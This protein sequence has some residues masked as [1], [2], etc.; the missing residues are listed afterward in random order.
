MRW[1]LQPL[2][3]SSGTLTSVAFH[4]RVEHIRGNA[5]DQLLS[6][7]LPNLTSIDLGCLVS[8]LPNTNSKVT[9][10]L[11][12]HPLLERVSLGHENL[13]PVESNVT[14]RIQLPT[15]DP[16]NEIARQGFL[17]HVYHLECVPTTL[18]PLITQR[19]PFISRLT[20]LS[21]AAQRN[22]FND[23]T[24]LQNAHATHPDASTLFTAVRHLRFQFPV[25]HRINFR[26]KHN[27]TIEEREFW[28]DLQN[29]SSQR[30]LWLMSWTAHQFS[31]IISWEGDLPPMQGVST[32]ASFIDSTRFANLSL[33]FQQ[34]ALASFFELYAHLETISVPQKT[35]LH[36]NPKNLKKLVAF[37][38]PLAYKCRT[39]KR[40]I[41]R[42]P[43]YSEK[44]VD[45]VFTFIRK[46]T[47]L[48]KVIIETIPDAAE[49]II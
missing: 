25:K 37:F 35:L 17:P 36:A 12:R 27:G 39:L 1:P 33:F 20:S 11:F 22:G 49:L 43:K 32:F 5:F 34:S 46:G 40:V 2:L 18:A 44:T 24:L 9:Q 6:M 19:A 48:S 41:G 3:Q 16:S 10:F 28:T 38:R 21:L 13:Q 23:I 14:Y 42:K 47:R 7:H 8:A 4:G 31:E 15:N 26:I 29:Y 45:N 30:Q